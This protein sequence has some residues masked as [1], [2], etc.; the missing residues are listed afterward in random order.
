[1][2]IQG[3]KQEKRSRKRLIPCESWIE[4]TKK[5]G[6]GSKKKILNQ[7]KLVSV[8]KTM[9]SPSRWKGSVYSDILKPMD[10][11]VK[12]EDGTLKWL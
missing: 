3:P 9:P 8:I 2:P 12:F 1:M 4:V 6:I 10:G 11:K 5:K 7:S